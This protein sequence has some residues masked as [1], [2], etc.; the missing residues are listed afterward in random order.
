MIKPTSITSAGRLQ[1]ERGETSKHTYMSR[2]EWVARGLLSVQGSSVEKD[3]LQLTSVLTNTLQLVSRDSVGCKY[4][5]F[6]TVATDNSKF[7]V[8]QM[9]RVTEM[10][11]LEKLMETS[12]DPKMLG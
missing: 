10:L 2:S 12:Q 11:P 4:N 8:L 5:N 9:G 6:A 1:G 3:G 7:H